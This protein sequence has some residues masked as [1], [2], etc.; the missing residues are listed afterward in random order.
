[1]LAASA[2]GVYFHVHG[3]YEAGPLD[4][5]FGARWET[6]SVLSRWW[7]SA[8]GGVGPSPPLAPGAMATAALALLAATIAYG[9]GTRRP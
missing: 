1:M 9:D 3:N 5:V 8:S 7:E 4:R 2:A 6:M